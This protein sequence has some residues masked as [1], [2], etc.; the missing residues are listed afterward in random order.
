[1]LDFAH[2]RHRDTM[3]Q[4]LLL[5]VVTL[6]KIRCQLVFQDGSFT[7]TS[8]YNTLPAIINSG[9]LNFSKF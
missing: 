6:I 4:I 9:K 1:M 5:L 3:L 8:P 2:Y 7:T